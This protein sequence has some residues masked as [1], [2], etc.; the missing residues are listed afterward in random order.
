MSARPKHGTD[1]LPA[2]PALDL[3]ST[4]QTAP[5]TTLRHTK[6][7]ADAGWPALLASLSFFLTTNLDDELFTSTLSSFQNFMTT[8]GVLG[9]TTPRDAFL[10]SLCKFAVPPT[11]VSQLANAESGQSTKAAAPASVLS[12][13]ADALGLT[14]QQTQFVTLSTRN[15]LCLR[16]LVGVSQAL[17]GSLD[18]TWFHVFEVLQNADFVIKANAFRKQKKRSAPPG[19]SALVG[20]SP[21]KSSAAF[22]S[23]AIAAT[24]ATHDVG[25]FMPS[26]A[27]EQAALQRN[28]RLLEVSQT[29]DSKAFQAFVSALCR[30]NS[31]MIGISASSE[32]DPGGTESGAMSPGR[33]PGGFFEEGASKQPRRIGTNVIRTLV[34]W[35]TLQFFARKAE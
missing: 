2:P 11:I 25:H 10:V 15:L 12:V 29:L 3:A 28:A 8:C 30:L 27:D 14:S 22:A 20:A 9:L 4:S 32:A 26:E 13:G 33:L 31:E 35:L 34:R 6:D 21:Q 16:S 23:S 5:Y 1:P 18:A 19:G 24:A 17:A 7:M